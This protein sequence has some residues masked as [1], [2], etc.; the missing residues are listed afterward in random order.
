MKAIGKNY[1]INENIT[2]NKYTLFYLLDD[3]YYWWTSTISPEF[4]MTDEHNL[5]RLREVY[6]YNIIKWLTEHEKPQ[7]HIDNCMQF[8]KY[9]SLILIDKDKIAFET[10]K[11]EILK[12]KTKT[13]TKRKKT[14]MIN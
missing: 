5:K 8:A 6:L 11:E 1:S 9:Y 14:K 13:K 4:D 12:P 7:E 10:N 3:E 2:K